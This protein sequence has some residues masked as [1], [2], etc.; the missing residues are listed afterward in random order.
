METTAAN[1]NLSRASWLI[2]IVDCQM[3]LVRRV[4]PQHGHQLHPEATLLL[5]YTRCPSINL[6]KLCRTDWIHSCYLCYP[7]FGRSK[8]PLSRIYYCHR[9][10]HQ[11]PRGPCTAALLSRHQLAMNS[12]H[13]TL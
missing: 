11:E 1:R 9:Q 5:P 4:V 10:D 12:S 7:E 13:S 3:Q 2:V 8:P 6:Y